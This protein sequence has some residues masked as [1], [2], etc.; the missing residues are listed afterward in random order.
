MA[1]TDTPSKNT[2]SQTQHDAHSSGAEFS[3]ASSS[4][5]LMQPASVSA[6]APHD[7]QAV[8]PTSADGPSRYTRSRTRLA[9][10]ASKAQSKVKNEDDGKAVAEQKPV[11]KK[12]KSV[13]EEK[14]LAKV[15][16]EKP[17]KKDQSVKD[18]K[19]VTNG[20]G[21]RKE[22]SV[23]D[24]KPSGG[25]LKRALSPSPKPEGKPAKR[26]K[27][28]AK[29]KTAKHRKAES[30]EPPKVLP[31]PPSETP[32]DRRA[33]LN[34]DALALVKYLRPA[35]DSDALRQLIYK[36]VKTAIKKRWSGSPVTLSGSSAYGA[37]LPSRCVCRILT[38]LNIS[39]E[40]SIDAAHSDVDLNVWVW[41]LPGWND[42]LGYEKA[43]SGALGSVLSVLRKAGIVESGYCVDAARV[44]VIHATA[45]EKYGS[46]TL[47]ITVNGGS[48]DSAAKTA[49]GLLDKYAYENNVKPGQTSARPPDFGLARSLVLLVKQFMTQ[50]KL[51]GGRF[52]GIG[53]Y[54]ILCLVISFLQHHDALN[55]GE[56]SD[57]HAHLGELLL[58]FFELYGEDFDYDQGISVRGD[59]SFFD[60]RNRQFQWESIRE[61][62][63]SRRYKWMDDEEIWAD[64]ERQQA[65]KEEA[66]K[67]R[68]LCIEDP[69]NSCDEIARATYHMPKIVDQLADFAET[70]R[71]AIDDDQPDV[72]HSFVGSV[73]GCAID[74][75]GSP[76]KRNAI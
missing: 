74:N 63:N 28:E 1:T 9:A 31:L 34:A 59:G 5:A 71:C 21:V 48:G 68:I 11:V 69:N 37:H 32:D 26:I 67:V 29:V 14:A 49:S 61:E 12:S 66:D 46:R 2:R 17:L 13:K 55:S 72:D 58:E 65:E 24:E 64:D 18:E 20:K 36:R 75:P 54:S 43:T 45:T 16:E 56:L 25:T 52:G 19:P 22:I 73:L 53:G 47:A 8:Q 35:P 70:L 10:A 3:E 38:A 4:A 23:K 33:L 41:K 39:A 62:R 51:L 7:V 50:Q 42:E 57:P 6:A 40:P 60:K 30:P 27:K 76:L 15:K 44:P